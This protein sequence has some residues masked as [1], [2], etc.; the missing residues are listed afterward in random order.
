[1]KD[2]PCLVLIWLAFCA[3]LI[4]LAVVVMRALRKDA[5]EVWHALGSPSLMEGNNL[6][7]MWKFW[8][9]IFHRRISLADS[10]ISKGTR[11]AIAALRLLTPVFALG[12]IAGTV[13][14][15][16]TGTQLLVQ[17]CSQVFGCHGLV[18]RPVARQVSDATWSWSSQGII[19]LL[20]VVALFGLQ[21]W[22]L[23]RVRIELPGVWKD[24]GE[25]SMNFFAPPIT[26][27]RFWAW[28]LVGWRLREAS[29]S[30]RM[31][32]LVYL[33]RMG[34]SAYLFSF[35]ARAFI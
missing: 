20:I 1:M 30:Q 12:L 32:V 4:L 7:A 14:G 15:L 27:L 35:I 3:A 34:T 24:R 28:V 11:R 13:L 31:R 25:P 19:D 21:A 17:T 23:R 5:P 29:V 18:A 33:L 10:G 6:G 2:I 16:T 8:S 26:Q 9:W 22:I